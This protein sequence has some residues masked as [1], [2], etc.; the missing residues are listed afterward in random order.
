ME[1]RSPRVQDPSEQSSG[2]SVC[3]KFVANGLPETLSV[4]AYAAGAPC[5]SWHIFRRPSPSMMVLDSSSRFVMQMTPPHRLWR[6]CMEYRRQ[7]GSLPHLPHHRGRRAAVMATY[8]TRQQL[9]DLV[10]THQLGPLSVALNLHPRQITLACR[11][12]AIPT[13]L[14]AYWQKVAAGREAKRKPLRGNP[15]DEVYGISPPTGPVPASGTATVAVS[16][17][18]QARDAF[19]FIR[20]RLVR[21]SSRGEVLELLWGSQVSVMLRPLAMDLAAMVVYDLQ[22]ALRRHG[23]TIELE[24]TGCLKVAYLQRRVVIQLYDTSAWEDP[25]LDLPRSLPTD[26]LVI[27]V[28]LSNLLD[29]GNRIWTFREDRPA[30][31]ARAGRLAQAIVVALRLWERPPSPDVAQPPTPAQEGGAPAEPIASDS[32]F[33]DSGRSS[34]Q[35]DA[36]GL[37]SP[38]QADRPIPLG[39]REFHNLVQEAEAWRHAQLLRDYAR[40]LRT[41]GAPQVVSTREPSGVIERLEAAADALD[42]TPHRIGATINRE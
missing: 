23:L 18:S 24:D 21:S 20:G 42:P 15:D 22:Q 31:Q 35:Q 29:D 32:S 17:S 37:V 3:S 12:Y 5:P 6:S 27:R 41:A 26:P 36:S 39:P 25:R 13:P 38:R 16:R 2:S 8:I 33:T 9:Y 19:A 30:V 10:W 28:V 1:P 14:G 40:H 34:G 7:Q 4:R 11:R